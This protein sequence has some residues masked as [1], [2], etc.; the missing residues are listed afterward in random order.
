MKI[1]QLK[2]TPSASRLM[3]IVSSVT[4]VDIMEASRRRPVVDARAIFYK[5]YKD[6]EGWPYV[7]IAALFGK[8]HASVIHG[9][10]AL[11]L[12]MV[13]DKRIKMLYDRCRNLYY[14]E[15]TIDDYLNK[16]E[17]LEKLSHLDGRILDLNAYI[18]EMEKEL[19]HFKKDPMSELYH[20]VRLHTP[21][22]KIEDA[23]KKVRAVLNGL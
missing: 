4:G 12:F 19:K 13:H 22:A 21:S 9:I 16:T 20:V 2:P 3:G 5:I 17:L 15:Q 8:D 18:A 1:K 23:K 11:D 14:G 10:K 6:M 7:D